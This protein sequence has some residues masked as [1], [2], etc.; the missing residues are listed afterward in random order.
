M[1]IPFTVQRISFARIS[2]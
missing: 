2:L 1:I